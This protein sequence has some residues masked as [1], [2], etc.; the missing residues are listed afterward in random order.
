MKEI[1]GL[2]QKEFVITIEWLVDCNILL[3]EGT[4]NTLEELRG[5]GSAD[6]IDIKLRD[7]ER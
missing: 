3:E 2:K 4:E 1:E 5:I 7:K 6:I